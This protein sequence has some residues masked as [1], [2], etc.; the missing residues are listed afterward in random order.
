MTIHYFETTVDAY[1]ACQCDDNL[2]DGDTLVIANEGVVGVVNCWPMAVTAIKCSLH[3]YNASR[4]N[5]CVSSYVAPTDIGA[6][7]IIAKNQGYAL[8]KDST[9][10]G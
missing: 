8:A 6:A 7:I 2:K 5:K 1:D 10:N 3:P 9:M 4:I